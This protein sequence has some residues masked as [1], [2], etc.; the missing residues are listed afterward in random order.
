[1]GLT[2]GYA[3]RKPMT[4]RHRAIFCRLLQF[5]GVDAIGSMMFDRYEVSA[6]LELT[7]LE[8]L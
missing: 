2:V 5:K 1:M 7:A 4:S 6:I 8:T 3:L